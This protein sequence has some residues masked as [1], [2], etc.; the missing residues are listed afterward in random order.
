M[1]D[2]RTIIITIASAI[3]SLSAVSCQKDS[4]LYYNN[5][6]MGNVVDG[7]FVS[8]QGNTFNIV[9]QTCD[10]RVDTMT[11][12]VMICDILNITKGEKNA[13]DVRLKQLAKV[14]TKQPLSAA[15]ATGD[16][17]VTDPI[18][19]SEVWF[20]GGYLNMH[21]MLPMSRGSKHLIN[22]VHEKNEDGSFTFELRHNA[23]GD[24]VSNSSSSLLLGGNYVS[25]PIVGTIGSGSARITLRW[26][27]YEAQADGYGWTGTEKEYKA[28]YDLG[29]LSS[30]PPVCTGSPEILQN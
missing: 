3:I 29:L 27:W 11:R 6:T 5:M 10:G 28:I 1:T 23:F 4:T 24:T 26:K 22:L 7:R 2:I 18:H 8:D 15:E 9:E 17:E 25:F 20:S 19:I 13:Y 30:T 16:A 21:V 14:L 12:A